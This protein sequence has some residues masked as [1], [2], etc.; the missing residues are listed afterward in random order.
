MSQK[1]VPVQA[2]VDAFADTGPG[3]CPRIK[4][5]RPEGRSFVEIHSMITGC[6]HVWRTRP[7]DQTEPWGFA[8]PRGLKMR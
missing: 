5:P 1:C 3:V 4:K 6:D 7:E 2:A 8:A